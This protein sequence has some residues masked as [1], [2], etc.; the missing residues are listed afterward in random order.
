MSAHLEKR[1]A[2]LKL[3]LEQQRDG[4]RDEAARVAIG[5]EV[6]LVDAWLARVRKSEKRVIREIHSGIGKAFDLW[7]PESALNEAVAE[8]TEKV[9]N[10]SNCTDTLRFTLAVR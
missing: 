4:T 1:L 6:D 9:W 3:T 7:V 5:R 8:A 10:A 2:S